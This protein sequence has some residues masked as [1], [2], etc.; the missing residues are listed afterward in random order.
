MQFDQHVLFIAKSLANAVISIRRDEL[1]WTTV[2]LWHHVAEAA[3]SD[4][5]DRIWSELNVHFAAGISGRLVAQLIEF[6]A[7][8]SRRPCLAPKRFIYFQFHFYRTPG[9]VHRSPPFH[10]PHSASS[11]TWFSVHITDNIV[12]EIWD[13]HVWQLMTMSKSSTWPL[14]CRDN[15]K[16]ESK[17]TKVTSCHSRHI[18]TTLLTVQLLNIVEFTVRFTL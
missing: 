4:E 10:Q 1:S 18:Y 14:L 6:A 17:V 12:V 7:L 11:T 9:A 13:M 8:M 15:M 5:S 3:T 16:S 2:C